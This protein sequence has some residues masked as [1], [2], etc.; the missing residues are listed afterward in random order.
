MHSIQTATPVCDLSA[1]ITRV[2][3]VCAEHVWLEFTTDAL[4]PSLPGQFLQVSC[5][6]ATL[7]AP[8]MLDWP[9]GTLPAVDPA[10]WSTEDTLLRR[11]FSIADRCTNADGSS[12]IVLISR[13]IG[14][15]TRWL[16]GLETGATLSVTGPLGQPFRLP[17]QARPVLLVGGGVGIPPMLYLAR[18]LSEAGQTD[19]TAI[20]GALSGDLLPVAR[21]EQPAPDGT[22]TR[23]L[24]LPGDGDY[25]AIVTTD[26]GSLGLRGRVTDGIRCW[27]AARGETAR[28]LVLAC[29]PEPMLGA[30][31]RLTR[32]LQMDC[33]L[34]IER[35]MGCG[36]G[37]CLSCVVKVFDPAADTGQRWALSCSEGPVFDRDQLCDFAENAREAR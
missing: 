12:T 30:V 31:A 29:G 28:P 5:H 17:A 36:L 13:A 3:H 22:P 24:E 6:D 32:A 2:W 26:D 23:C 9:E 8:R 1:T 4:P 34:C 37:T 19:V 14:R 16:D 35:M 11:P 27:Q 25:P 7:D 33:Q 15:G 10:N 21:R 18:A 20:F